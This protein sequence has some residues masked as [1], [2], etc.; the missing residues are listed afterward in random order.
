MT[1][2]IAHSSGLAPL[3]TPAMM[4]LV[5]LATLPGITALTWFFGYGTLLNVLWASAL[6]LACE[7]LALR[8]R[9]RAP[10]FHLRDGSAL[11]TAVLL[12]IALPPATPW[13]LIAIGIGFAILIAKHLYGG[14]GH[15]PFNP[16]MVG[17][18]VLLVSFPA[19][20]NVWP[21]PAGAGGELLGPL[22]ALLHSL[23][24]GEPLDGFT[25][26]TPLDVF[27]HN[28]ALLVEDLWAQYPQFGRWGGR[29]WEWVNL[30]FLGGGLLLLQRRLFS[31]HAPVAMLATLAVLAALFYD[32]GSSASGGSPLYHLF[33]GATMLGAFF[34]V[35]EP[36]TSASSE[37]G[38]LLYGAG[39]GA[40]VYIIRRWGGYPDAIAFAVLLMNFAAPL[41]DRYT[42]PRT[43]G[44]GANRHH[45]T[46][47]EVSNKASNGTDQGGE[48]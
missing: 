35:T 27:R 9:R 11:V 47:T 21:A 39:I 28:Q 12:G 32:G 29:G 13:W 10:L 25:M 17:Y 26:A 42:L 38:R 40:L 24:L 31:W 18:A 20:M 45:E 48:H 41:L 7:A 6:A 4:R 44:H 46:S 14:L 23:G 19:Q 30:A 37:R 34:I 36:V 1:L 16:A 8:L 43:Y 3:D 33:S 2:P 5:V 15:N 22:T